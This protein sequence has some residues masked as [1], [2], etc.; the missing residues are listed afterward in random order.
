M[1]DWG[2]N[3]LGSGTSLYNLKCICVLG[4]GHLHIMQELIFVNHLGYHINYTSDMTE[5]NSM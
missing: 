1:M 2:N 3:G 4:G 5:L